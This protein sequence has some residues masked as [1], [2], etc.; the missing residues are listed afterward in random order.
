M[1]REVEFAFGN[2]MP[3]AP[4]LGAN[5]FQ[6]PISL[7]RFPWKKMLS[8]SW[9]SCPSAESLPLL[10]LQGGEV[11]VQAVLGGWD[12][13]VHMPSGHWIV[14]V[15]TDST[16]WSTAM[17]TQSVTE[18]RSVGCVSAQGQLPFVDKVTTELLL[19]LPL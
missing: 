3:Q 9:G 5:Y 7:C 10:P 14:P 17:R 15:F 6:D 13:N 8:S 19:P 11:G 2:E 1:A 12:E 16:V 18:V 4:E